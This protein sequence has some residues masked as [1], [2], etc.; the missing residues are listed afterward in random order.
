MGKNIVI[1]RV[2]KIPKEI[3]EKVLQTKIDNDLFLKG[4]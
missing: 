3:V 4:V 2:K 1:G